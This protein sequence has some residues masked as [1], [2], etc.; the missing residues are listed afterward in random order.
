MTDLTLTLII[1][2]LAMHGSDLS[3]MRSE[4]NGEEPTM[5]RLIWNL[6]ITL[7]FAGVGIAWI[8]ESF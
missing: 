5:P 1:S 2:W 6:I 8:I 4:M 7:V 3:I